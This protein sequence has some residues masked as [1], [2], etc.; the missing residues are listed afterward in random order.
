MG[1]RTLRV[2]AVMALLALV[3]AACRGDD[4]GLGVDDDG[5]PVTD[6]GEPDT[7]EEKTVERVAGELVVGTTDTVTSLDPARVRDYYSA[8]VLLNV[9]ETLV[10]F[11]PGATEVTPLLAEEVAVSEDGLVHTFRLREGVAFHDGSTLDSEDVRFSLERATAINHPRGAAFLLGD[12][13][14]IETPDEHTVSITLTA[15][16]ATFLARLAYPVGTVVPSGG[17]YTA[18][19]PEP[20]DDADDAEVDPG[21]FVNEELVATG[22]YRLADVVEGESVTLEAFGDYWGQAPR[23]DRVVLRSFETSGELRRALESG[24]V[25]VAFR[26]LSPEQRAELAETEGVQ[27]VAGQGAQVRYLVFNPAHAP[28]DDV[29]VRRAVAAALDRDRIVTDV[30]DGAAEPLHSMVPPGFDASADHFSAHDDPAGLLE[31][32]ETPVAID[33]HYAGERYGAAEPTLARHIQEALEETG[34]FEVSVTST[35]WEQFTEE[36]WPA[37][38]GEYPAFLLGWYP[39]YF[40]PDAYLEPFYSSTGFLGV[41][42]DAETDELLARQHQADEQERREILDRIQEIAA[43]QVPIVP[44]FAETPTAYAAEDVTGLDETMD[45]VGIMR[46]GLLEP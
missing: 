19:D 24:E 29:N 33:L 18:P 11:E 43:D 21:E 25:D 7:G 1:Q 14:T 42:A 9:G 38:E 6:D 28:V 40:D 15:P 26:E 5:P 8:N 10:G 36:A 16:S 17:D 46:Y 44:L 41:F 22:P 31:G 30:F 32:R 45:L 35:D 4:G 39:D 37:A 27:L 12:I 20:G 3:T 2:V 23:N 34:L 13:D